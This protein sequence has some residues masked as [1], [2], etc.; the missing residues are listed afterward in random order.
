MRQSTWSPDPTVPY[1]P[2]PWERVTY[3]EN[4]AIVG[5]EDGVIPIGGRQI[6]WDYDDIVISLTNI[7]ATRPSIPPI[8]VIPEPETYA[9][10]LA[11]LGVVGAVA[12]RRKVK[13]N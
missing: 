11:G 9:M 3:T 13:V 2:G 1:F 12:R 8:P 7:G 5:F 10:L 4:G 6:D